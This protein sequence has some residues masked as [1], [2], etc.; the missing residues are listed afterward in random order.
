MTTFDPN[1]L[2]IDFD[3]LDEQTPVKK[4]D[5]TQWSDPLDQLATTKTS[6][7][8]KPEEKKETSPRGETPIKKVAPIQKSAEKKSETGESAIV[9]DINLSSIDDIMGLI[10]ENK[11]SF[12]TL[13][14]SPQNY[15]EVI[16][17]DENTPVMTKR[18]S[19]PVYTQILLKMKAMTQ[20]VVENTTEVQSGTGELK[21]KNTWYKLATKT[22]PDPFG[23]KIFFKASPVAKKV[24]AQRQQAASFTTMLK[25]MGVVAF[26]FLVL[27]G[28]FLTFVVLN[29][30][31]VDDVNFFL[32]LWINPNN[33]NIFI[34][35]I[36]TVL[37]MVLVFLETV[38]ACIYGFK[39]LVAKKSEKR[40]K[41]V[42]GILATVF[43]VITFV[44]ATMWL[45]ID[46]KIKELPNW[47][48]VARGSV[49][50]YDSSVLTSTRF[51][52]DDALLSSTDLKNLIGPINIRFDVSVLADNEA[53][54]G[55]T[56]QK[57]IWDF[58][59]WIDNQQTLV[60]TTQPLVFYDFDS[61]RTYDVTLI[62][63]GV[64][65]VGKQLTKTQA[66]PTIEVTDLIEIDEQIL[67]SGWKMLRFN[68]ESLK[69]KGTLEWYYGDDFQEPVSKWYI[70]QPGKPIFDETIIALS[71]KNSLGITKQAFDRV[72][73][74]QPNAGDE[75]S[76]T[77]RSEVDLE[78]DMLYNFRVED[79]ENDFGDGIIESFVWDID[80]TQLTREWD[81]SNP[82]Q[83]SQVSYEFSRFGD[84]EIRATLTDSLWQSTTLT[85]TLD[86]DKKLLLTT[87]L[88]IFNQQAPI[89]NMSY[90]A[91]QW[92]Y[93]I[94]ELGIPTTLTLSARKIKTQDPLYSL[95]SVSWD[96]NNDG[97]IDQ[98][99]DYIDH[100]ILLAGD[101]AITAY[102]TFIH[103]KQNTT[104]QASEVL[105][106]QAIKKDV[107][108][109]LD[110][111][112]DTQYVPVTVRFDA[113]RSRVLGQD[114]V[115]FEYDYGDGI[116]EDRD[117]INPWHIYRTPG[118]YD[119]VLTVTTDRWEKYSI[120]KKLIL[121]NKPD[122]VKITPS[123]YTAPVYQEIDFSSHESSGQIV[124]YYWDFGDGNTSSQANPSHN[125]TT[126]GNYDVT[127]LIEFSNNNAKTDEIEI[128]VHP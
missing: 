8:V 119:I 28:A 52:A 88:E 60:E 84:H 51:D 13:E 77:I 91:K 25:F 117:A 65:S 2:D 18:I 43:L 41:V 127:L 90:Q 19:Y 102:Y 16:F 67:D 53:R 79:I 82:S 40:K 58:N 100:E 4:V 105:Y 10:I 17:R 47:W 123:L 120:N 63:E 76:W 3:N 21:Y 14:P 64:D 128:Q 24:A 35:K 6:A 7:V 87:P 30:K 29:A 5:T 72:F 103:R 54:R 37:F 83:A 62:L 97:D 20:L 74:I 111:E 95:Q 106:I 48:D 73:V 34:Q 92:E 59:G 124:S 66:I 23:E 22:S 93:I 15:V 71:V 110:I 33:I 68:G 96:L 12:V 126:P 115:K 80:G 70:F 50:I 86:I 85:Y 32:S 101:T 89:E 38:F 69:Q 104:I 56:I 1:K 94:D 98:S 116:V 46:K 36:V 45:V 9:Y 125:Y 107:I 113:S 108:L 57:Y 27:W 31:T 75:I 122:I 78:N 99:W 114:I 26:L 44:T 11:Y 109:E 49:Q 121:T 61:V 112:K 42:S 118:D 81:I 39:F 55:F